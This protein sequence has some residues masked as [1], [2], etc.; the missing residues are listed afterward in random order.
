MDG[1]RYIWKTLKVTTPPSRVV[2]LL[3]FTKWLS[4][5]GFRVPIPL[6]TVRGV[7]LC[8]TPD[9]RGG[10]ETG[11]LQPWLG[12]SHLSLSDDRERRAA[13]STVAHL[14]QATA[15][16]AKGYVPS[17]LSLRLRRKYDLL[18]RMWPKLVTALP[19]YGELAGILFKG[20]QRAILAAERGNVRDAR[21][22]DLRRSWCH[23][24]L[25]PHN[26]LWDGE[27]VGLI[28]FDLA[29]PDDPLTDVVQL[30][31]HALVLDAVDQYG[32]HEMGRQY[33]TEASLSEGQEQRLWDLLWFPDF[34][35]RSLTEWMN[36]GNF[37]ETAPLWRAIEVEHKRFDWLSGGNS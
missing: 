21:L 31:N 18:A 1:S 35:L 26:I 36:S 13:L 7:T 25:A 34:L 8:Q 17:L 32:W 16:N 3:Q 10:Y 11:Y 28:D 24:D 23:R 29:A 9:G 12:G 22:P 6:L 37:D 27:T 19:D 2:E 4:E 30:C 15:V 33:A 14:H 20:A 5:L